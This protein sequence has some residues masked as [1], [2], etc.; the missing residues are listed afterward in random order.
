[1]LHLS[2]LVVELDEA[3]GDVFLGEGGEAVFHSGADIGL[4]KARQHVSNFP[5]YIVQ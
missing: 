4:L 2:D 3:G 5:M 1:M